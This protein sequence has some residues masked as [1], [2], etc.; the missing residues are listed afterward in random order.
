[1]M[2]SASDSTS[3]LRVARYARTVDNRDDVDPIRQKLEAAQAKERE[4]DDR[5][6]A[7]HEAG[8]LA[9]LARRRVAVGEVLIW[10]TGEEGFRS[11]TGKTHHGETPDSALLV[12]CA[13]AGTAAEFADRDVT[14]LPPTADS[15]YR[16]A[17]AAAWIHAHP[18]D[19]V[20]HGANADEAEAWLRQ[21]WGKA[22]QDAATI[23][24]V[25]EAWMEVKEE[26]AAGIEGVRNLADGILEA[27]RC[28]LGPEEAA[29]LVQQVMD[30]EDVPFDVSAV[31]GVG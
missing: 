11:W 14:G 9:A 23:A 21:L 5:A 7:I 15:D 4:G 10:D 30:L 28:R 20:P 25:R 27:D 24:H 22:H 26:M 18:E 29:A 12:P 1:M 3:D 31:S 6:A 17:V 16:D 8:H 2:T 19:E 13:L